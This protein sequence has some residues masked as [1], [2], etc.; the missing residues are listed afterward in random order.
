MK[1]LIADDHSYNRD[2]LRFILEDEG[3]QCVE[4]ENGRIAIEIFRNELDVALVLMDINMPEMDGIVATE[5]I[6]KIRGDRYVTIIFVTALDNPEVLVQCL[7]AGGDDF[8]PKPINENVL[9]SKVNAHARNQV[10]Y[11]NLSKA[12]AEL[13]LHHQAIA[14]EHSIVEHVFTNGLDRLDT[15]CENLLTYT[16]PMSMFNGDLVLSAPS[17]S[18]GQYVLVGDF[19]G[20][21][22]SAA[23]G[24]L[25]V[26]SVFFSHVP[27]QA[28]VS[29]LAIEINQQLHRLLP[30]GMFFCATLMHVEKCGTRIS[31]WSGGMNDTLLIDPDGA[32]IRALSGDHMP[33]GILNEHEFDSSIQLHDVAEGSRLIIY[34]DGVN[35]A[36]NQDGM[37][38]GEERIVSL[39]KS[40]K[41]NFVQEIIRAVREFRGDEQQDDD[42][43]AIEF[44]CVPCVHND[45]INGEVVDVA[46]DYHAAECFPWRLNL[47]L[48]STD[49]KRTD[50]VQQSVSFLSA[51]KGV[52][53]HQHKL[54]VIMSELF[55]NA[56]EHGVL[57][58]ESSIKDTADGFERY[59]QLREE[60]LN[61]IV[62]QSIGIELEY[63]RGSPNRIR[64][65]ITD[66]GD[67]F[68]FQKK[69][70]ELEA[71]E[72]SHGRGLNLLSTL[73]A[74]LEYS[75][76]GKT[77]TAYYDFC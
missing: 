22:L 39:L 48:N 67:G 31:L 23:V 24:S 47:T 76:G 54:F 17:P 57:R 5:N 44:L 69:Q 52:E 7:D 27:K 30:L 50:I 58:L 6:C 11:N 45:K 12:H 3:H 36:K 74:H 53:L 19:T 18:G 34:T 77:V 29:E 35:E 21:G 15:R 46:A 66:S 10:I 49:L 20:H 71:N 37:E 43:S 14:R 72:N 63:I 55:N 2:L 25:P 40:S 1:I 13:K 32:T 68:D 26:M 38:F 4:A 16:S 28:S 51:I 62:D 59:Y 33:L 64:L 75:N 8:V 61:S 65:V 56:L 42:I 41:S 60:R 70:N 9:L 73:C